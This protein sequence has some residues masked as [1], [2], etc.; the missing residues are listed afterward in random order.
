M[1]SYLGLAPRNRIREVIRS[2][3]LT[4]T[5]YETAE[6]Y[7]ADIL[8]Q[9]NVI[10]ELQ[11]RSLI[12]NLKKTKHYTNFLHNSG[13]FNNVKKITTM[14]ELLQIKQGELVVFTQTLANTDRPVHAMVSVGNGRFAGVKNNLLDV[15]L[16]DGKKIITAEQLGQFD[17]GILKHSSSLEAAGL[18]VWAG[19]PKGAKYSYGQPIE[20]VARKLASEP[21]ANSAKCVAELLEQSGELSSE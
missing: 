9:A 7:I 18:N 15:N 1:M 12:E 11:E 17:S 6:L 19:Y 14:D 20:E 2:N 3:M 5:K 8:K 13:L 10:N 4:G 16:G 21:I